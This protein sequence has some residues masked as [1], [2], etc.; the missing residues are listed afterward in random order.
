VGWIG[1]QWL[2]PPLCLCACVSLWLRP[3]RGV[4]RGRFTNEADQ[5]QRKGSWYHR[6]GVCFPRLLVPVCL[7][8]LGWHSDRGFM[9]K[10]ASPMRG[11]TQGQTQGSWCSRAGA[12]HCPCARVPVSFWL[13]SQIGGFESTDQQADLGLRRKEAGAH[14]AQVCASHVPQPVCP[15]FL[16]WHSDRGLRVGAFTNEGQTQGPDAR[17]WCSMRRCVS[18]PAVCVPVFPWSYL[19]GV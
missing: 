5:G 1:A 15:C 3:D 2:L 16:G 6:T 10:G 14:N 11:R 7:C 13:A 8:F 4:L 17:S 18:Y 12:S 9:R 19:T